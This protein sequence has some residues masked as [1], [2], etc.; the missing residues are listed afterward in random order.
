MPVEKIRIGKAIYLAEG[1]PFTRPKRQDTYQ[2]EAPSLEKMRGPGGRLHF[3]GDGVQKPAERPK[4]YV[5][6]R[7]IQVGNAVHFAEN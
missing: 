1:E 6:A 7:K 2:R 4:A 5:P 3:A